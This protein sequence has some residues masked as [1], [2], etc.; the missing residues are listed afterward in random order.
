MLLSPSR[1][2]TIVLSSTGWSHV[3]ALVGSATFVA[4]GVLVGLQLGGTD[5]A[6]VVLAVAL[7]AVATTGLGVL[8]AASVI[9]LKRGNPLGAAIAAACVVLG[10]VFYPVTA[11]PAVLQPLSLF[12]PTTW[13]LAA[14]RG[15]ILGGLGLAELA[16][17]LLGLGILAILLL[18]TGLAAFAAVIRFA[19]SDGSLGQY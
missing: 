7:L 1:L 8:T 4:F 14:I 3:S 11:L 18:A 15:A 13:A 2:S 9:V 19:R 12:V 17:A 6:A 16:P 10:G 5:W